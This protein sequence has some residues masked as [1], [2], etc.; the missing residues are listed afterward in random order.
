MPQQAE[1]AAGADIADLDLVHDVPLSSHAV[2]EVAGQVPA[3]S[4]I[5]F[6]P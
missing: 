5:G 2:N 3:G 6:S 1:Q 4:M